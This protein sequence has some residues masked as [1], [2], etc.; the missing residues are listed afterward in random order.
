VCSLAFFA[1]QKGKLA[2][3]NKRQLNSKIGSIINMRV[4]I[5][6]EAIYKGD[7]SFLSRRG[8]QGGGT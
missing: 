1:L 7:Q 5:P 4:G 8:I 2:R 6:L 3:E